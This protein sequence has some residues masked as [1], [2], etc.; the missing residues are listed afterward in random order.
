M[1][2]QTPLSQLSDG[3]VGPTSSASSELSHAGAVWATT[4]IARLPTAT[5]GLIKVKRE[6]FTT[7]F[8]D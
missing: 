8:D 5:R 7:Q 6:K 4:S 3:V 1:V 2:G